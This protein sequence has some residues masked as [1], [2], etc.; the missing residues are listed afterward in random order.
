MTTVT[1]DNVAKQ[2]LKITTTPVSRL[3]V[4]EESSPAGRTRIEMS[5]DEALEL[6]MALLKELIL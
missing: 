3:V 4:L 2:E 5:R 1:L 6:T